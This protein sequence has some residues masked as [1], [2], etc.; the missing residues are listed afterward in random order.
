MKDVAEEEGG[1]GTAGGEAFG[2][3]LRLEE[4]V[5]QQL[6]AAGHGRVL[7][8]EETLALGKHVRHAVLHEE[9][10][11]WEPVREGDGDV[12]AAAA[13]V[14]DSAIEGVPREQVTECARFAVDCFFLLV[15]ALYR[16]RE[17]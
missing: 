12:P 15:I 7:D 8:R 6:D 2:R 9:G 1:Y 17:T 5:L 3:R 4:V 13:H 14:D 16:C 10:E 11:V